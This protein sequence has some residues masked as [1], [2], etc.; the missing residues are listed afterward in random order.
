MVQLLSPKA[1]PYNSFCFISA[2]DS[3]KYGLSTA[4]LLWLISEGLFIHKL[5]SDLGLTRSLPLRLDLSPM[6]DVN[7]RSIGRKWKPY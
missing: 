4:G 5:Y 1:E 3:S 7:F 6:K 2:F